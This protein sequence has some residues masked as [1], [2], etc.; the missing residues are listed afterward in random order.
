M[1]EEPR[2]PVVRERE[3]PEPHEEPLAPPVVRE[4]EVEHREVCPPP[5][6]TRTS[7]LALASLATGLSAYFIFPIAGAIAAIVTGFLAH[8]EI[9]ASNGRVTG[10]AFATAGLVLG[11]L[12]IGLIILFIALATIF[13]SAV[14]GSSASL[15]RLHIGG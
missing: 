8:N 15:S 6:P 4:K 1:A 7:A 2:G 14:P 13:A 9:R 5:P 3:A 12:Q 11:W 10:S